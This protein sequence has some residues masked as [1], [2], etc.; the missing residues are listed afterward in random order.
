[1][2]TNLVDES[3][4]L[5]KGLNDLS[6]S[7][8]LIIYNPLE[9]AVES[10]E[11]YLS[12]YGQSKKKI[13]FM[14]MNPGPWGMVQTGIPF[15]AIDPVKNFLKIEKNI[16]APKKQH[17]KRPVQG[18]SCKR[19]EVSG[20]RLWSWIEAQWGDA[21]SFFSDCFVHNYCPL[22]FFDSGGKNITPE[23]LNMVERIALEEICDNFLLK[24]VSVLGCEWIIG[25]GNYAEA[26]AKKVFKDKEVKVGRIL[27]PSPA[28]P[29]A[30][31]GWAGFATE[32]MIAYGLM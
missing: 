17:Q 9:Y 19:Q 14:G 26:K 22:A 2:N 11:F 5:T 4:T 31:K 32:K 3:R 13:L 12:R 25:V 16:N 6:F 1:M 29:L 30:N 18:F 20:S 23:K 21:E 28:S 24:M 7:K 8:D 27:H 15:G 10:H